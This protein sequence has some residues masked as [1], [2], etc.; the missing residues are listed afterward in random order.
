MGVVIV[1]K[2]RLERLFC[3]TVDHQTKEDQTVTLRHRDTMEQ[4]RIPI[5][6]LR[7]VISKEVDMRNWLKKQF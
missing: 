2:M 1:G 4:I 5:S 7:S 3:I 6:E